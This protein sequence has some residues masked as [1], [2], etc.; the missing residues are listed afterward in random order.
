M[1]RKLRQIARRES[2][3]LCRRCARL[4]PEEDYPE[5]TDW[6]CQTCVADKVPAAM[7]LEEHG[8]HQRYNTS[9][10]F[11]GLRV[12]KV[13]QGFLREQYEV[14]VPSQDGEFF[15]VAEACVGL[16]TKTTN[17]ANRLLKEFP[18]ARLFTQG[19]D[20]RCVIHLPVAVFPRMARRCGAFK[21]RAGQPRT[22]AQIEMQKKA[23]ERLAEHRKTASEQKATQLTLL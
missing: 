2:T 3:R 18:Q 11:A 6:I 8:N 9:K 4:V 1:A 16:Y 7:P 22:E 10:V 5:G 17:M 21:S 15:P 13:M 23:A 20:G 19:G 12:K 14:E